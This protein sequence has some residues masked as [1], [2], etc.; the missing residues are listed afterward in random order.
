MA[1]PTYKKV[2][3]KSWTALVEDLE[4]VELLDQ[5]IECEFLS[6]TTINDLKDI[7]IRSE[8]N[9]AVLDRVMM[10]GPEKYEKF[11]EC[12]RKT[13]QES[14]VKILEEKEREVEAHVEA[15]IVP[16]IAN[17]LHAPPTGLTS[18]QNNTL[19]SGAQHFDSASVPAPSMKVQAVTKTVPLDPTDETLH[20]LGDSIMYRNIAVDGTQPSGT[21][22]QAAAGTE[23][24]SQSTTTT[25][26][27]ATAGPR[28]PD[29]TD[30][31]LQ[32]LS[33]DFSPYMT[34]LEDKSLLNIARKLTRNEGLHLAMRVL[35]YDIYKKIEQNP[36]LK[37]TVN[38]NMEVLMQWKDAR[39]KDYEKNYNELKKVIGGLERNDIVYCMEKC[40][41]EGKRF[42]C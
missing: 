24:G 33:D 11:K 7:K 35:S 6:R 1:E 10:S 29:D 41:M 28:K 2:L 37:T 16:V 25:A 42:S 19:P 9:R 18:S 4:S 31:E 12:L 40:V 32:C 30:K 34:I 8:R 38:I 26:A 39:D 36:S 17:R 27:G 13:K 5:F 23:A 20:H 21:L 22:I 3:S 14:L 15:H